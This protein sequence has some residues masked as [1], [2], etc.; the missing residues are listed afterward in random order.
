MNKLK[1][2]LVD[3]QRMFAE[4]LKI[5]LTNYAEEVEIMGIC[6]NGKEACDFVESQRPDIILMDVH[7]PVMDGVE[8]VAKIK[9]GHP[10]IKIIMLSTYDEDES[11]R[12]ALI[13]GASGYL[14]KDIS[15]TELIVSIRALNSGMIQISPSIAKK[16]I[17]STYVE[18]KDGGGKDMDKTFPWFDTLTEREREIFALLA[19]G[20]DNAQISEELGISP[21]TVRNRVSTIYSKL[22]VKDRFEII[23]LANRI[24]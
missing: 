23:Q 2:L 3:D 1:L 6:P 16:L 5:Y 24:R 17:Q 22:E 18:K 10:D 7:M 20:K 19:T 11:V 14:L 12:S 9:A 4:S 15:P 8:A 13:S 21:Q